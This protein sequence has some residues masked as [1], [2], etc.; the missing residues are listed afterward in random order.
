M[1][2][3]ERELVLTK[4][5][6]WQYEREWRFTWAEPP[7]TQEEFKD[8][9]FPNSSLVEI[10][11]GSRIPEVPAAEL[12]KLADG[13]RKTARHFRMSVHPCRF[14]LQR[15]ELPELKSTSFSRP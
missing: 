3:L 1:P 2:D 9:R 15:T 11:L 4:H 8:V 6:D 12:R 7:N 14:A 5:S 10:L 13:L